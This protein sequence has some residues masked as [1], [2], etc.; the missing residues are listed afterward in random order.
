MNF[1]WNLAKEEYNKLQTEHKQSSSLVQSL[2]QEIE[3]LNVKHEKQE[4]EIE[5][6]KS[7]L[8]ASENSFDELNNTLNTTTIKLKVEW[9]NHCVTM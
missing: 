4:I 5:A 2:K 6:M 3:S 9:L 1:I 8:G 7:K